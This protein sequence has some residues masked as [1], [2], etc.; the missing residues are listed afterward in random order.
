MRAVNSLVVR[1]LLVTAVKNPFTLVMRGFWHLGNSGATVIDS[2]S[3]SPEN[4]PPPLATGP[5]MDLAQWETDLDHI[6]RSRRFKG[7]ADL[8]IDG[9]KFLSLIHISSKAAENSVINAASAV[10]VAFPAMSRSLPRHSSSRASA[11]RPA[12]NPSRVKLK[13]SR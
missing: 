7:R 10:A 6:V 9:E 12:R 2:G 8:L 3:E 1:S 11:V 5:G 13:D 4:P